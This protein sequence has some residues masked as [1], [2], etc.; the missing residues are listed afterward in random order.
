MQ[1]LAE[2]Q[3]LAETLKGIL[4]TLG[5]ELSEIE[6]R[7]HGMFVE[8]SYKERPE[9][10]QFWETLRSGR[11]YLLPS[12]PGLMGGFGSGHFFSAVAPAIRSERRGSDIF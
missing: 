10:R 2:A 9:Y 7:H 11:P 4:S 5:Y 8:P 1:E 6:G 12:P 3:R